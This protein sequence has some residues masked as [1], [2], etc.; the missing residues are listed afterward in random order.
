[1]KKGGRQDREE[2]HRL[3]TD[4]RRG[5]AEVRELAKVGERENPTLSKTK[6]AG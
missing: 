6:S 5:W 2:E 1:M 4:R 3:V